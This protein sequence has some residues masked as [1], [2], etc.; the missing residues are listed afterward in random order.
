[1]LYAVKLL[2][3]LERYVMETELLTVGRRQAL[4]CQGSWGDWC[5]AHGSRNYKVMI[6]LRNSMIQEYA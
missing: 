3:V 2:D 6:V 5:G 4:F 1:M